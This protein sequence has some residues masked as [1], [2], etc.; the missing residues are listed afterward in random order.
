MIPQ[1]DEA[2]W[3]KARLGRLTASRVSDALARIKVGWSTSRANYAAELV[4]ER[5]T[6]VAGDRFVSGPMQWGLDCEAQARRAYEFYNDVTMAPAAFVIHPRL[7]W[8][9]ASPDGF[10]GD[11]GLWECKCPN[12]N[13]HIKTLRAGTIPSEYVQQMQWQL[14]CTGR[15][16]VD[17]TSFD[18]RL[19]EE[20]RLFVRRLERD[21]KAIAA[22]EADVEVFLAEVDA[23]VAELRER[24]AA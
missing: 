21:D 15:K 23:L 8:A 24:C 22:L 19:P 12:T 14:C 20:M 4:A 5:L 18:P 3:A 7:E 9:G 2:A 17:F 16:W 6:G 10:I 13:T 11:D 1:S